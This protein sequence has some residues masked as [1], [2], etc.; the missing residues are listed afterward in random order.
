MTPETYLDDRPALQA[1]QC[2]IEQWR[3]DARDEAPHS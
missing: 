1:L 2:R 3:Q